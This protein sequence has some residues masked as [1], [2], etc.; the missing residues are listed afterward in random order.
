VEE[1]ALPALALTPLAWTAVRLAALAA[2]ALYAS[3]RASDPK[4]GVHEQVLDGLPEGLGGHSHRAEAERSVHG[5]A[6]FRRI[7]RLRGAALE[8]EAA[9]LGRVR[10][11]RVG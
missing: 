5:T 11:R 10:L 2:V 6:R 1:A 8:L 3:R 7:L 9:G 4:D